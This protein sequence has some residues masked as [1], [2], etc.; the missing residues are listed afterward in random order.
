MRGSEE[1]LIWPEALN[2][3]SITGQGV[4]A[5]ICNKEVI[6]GNKSLMLEQGIAIPVEAEEALAETTGLAQ[7]GVLVSIDKEV[8]GVL[9]IS[10]PLKPEAPE[11][12]FILKSMNIES[13]I[14]TGDNWGT[15][16][17]IAKQVGIDSKY[18]VA[19]AKPEQKAEKVKELQVEADV[20]LLSAFHH[21]NI[22]LLHMLQLFQLRG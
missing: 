21:S 10:D 22:Y 8:I 16:N 2:F 18:V 17:A 13:M 4:K 3:E 9:A 19:E 5:I 1:K 15:A 11:V 12:I 14:V 6:V 20:Q 7:T